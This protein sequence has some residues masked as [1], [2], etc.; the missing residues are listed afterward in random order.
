MKLFLL[1]MRPHKSYSLPLYNCFHVFP[2]DCNPNVPCNGIFPLHR[3]RIK[4]AGIKVLLRNVE[5]FAEI[6]NLSS[7]SGYK[8]LKSA[9]TLNIS[10][11]CSS[12]LATFFIFSVLSEIF[13]TVLLTSVTEA[14][15]SSVLAAFS[16]AIAVKL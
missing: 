9:Y 11:F 16:S 5:N 15:V 13:V 7:C 2:T 12:L 8:L 4:V 3:V 1:P 10:M 6:M 14:E